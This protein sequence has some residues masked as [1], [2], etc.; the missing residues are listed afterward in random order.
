MFLVNIYGPNRDDIFFY[1]S[2]MV[3]IHEAAAER[4]LI[5]DG[6][7]NLVLNHDMDSY[8]YKHVNN[9]DVRDQVLDMLVDY[10]LIGVW[11]DLNIEEKQFTWR[12]KLTDRKPRLD[13]F[14]ISESYS[15]KQIVQKYVLVIELIIL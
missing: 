10:N 6:D 13:F 14:L 11:R 15:W 9:P 8:N 4:P 7:F 5:I 1:M 12:R 2:L 3:D